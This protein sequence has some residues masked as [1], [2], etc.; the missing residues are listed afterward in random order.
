MDG[1]FRVR[2]LS[3]VQAHPRPPI[4]T[5]INNH[6]S[7]HHRKNN[8]AGAV[9]EISDLKLL[10]GVGNLPTENVRLQVSTKLKN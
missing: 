1:R 4:T 9:N 8:A 6:L 3:V 5:P 7:H 2:S 10:D